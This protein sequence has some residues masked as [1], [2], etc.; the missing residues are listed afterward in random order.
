MN[1]DDRAYRLVYR[2]YD[3]PSPRCVVIISFAEHNP[4]YSRVWA[5]PPQERSQGEAPQW[6]LYSYLWRVWKQIV[7]IYVSDYALAKIIY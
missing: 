6:V 3:S 2:A 7:V 5:N 1:F 4:A